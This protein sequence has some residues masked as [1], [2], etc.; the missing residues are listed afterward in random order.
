MHVLKYFV[1]DLLERVFI[2]KEKQTY[3]SAFLFL[4]TYIVKCTQC[5]YIQLH[6]EAIYTT[7][8]L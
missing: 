3:F 7:I 4:F 8:T 5:A 1:T 6:I 2:K